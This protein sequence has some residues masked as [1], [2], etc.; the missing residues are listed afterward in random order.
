[1]EEHL[2]AEAGMSKSGGTQGCTIS[3]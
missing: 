1:V 3:L 2:A